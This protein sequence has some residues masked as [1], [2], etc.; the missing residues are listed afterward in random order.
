MLFDHVGIA[1]ETPADLDK[2][3]RR[4][5]L[6]EKS[7]FFWMMLA[8]TAKYIARQDAV[9]VQGFL[10]TLHHLLDDIEHL[11]TDSPLTYR[12]GSLMTLQPTH[13][14]QIVTCRALMQRMQMLMP[15]IIALGVDLPPAPVTTIEQLLDL[16]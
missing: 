4:D 9:K 3:Q 12:R 15:Q 1:V 11:L 13:D 10:D 5:L 6:S 16:H 7:A 2:V 14:A 8:I